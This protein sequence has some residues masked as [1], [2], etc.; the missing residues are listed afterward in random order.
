MFN[1]KKN[2]LA[3]VLLMGMAASAGANAASNATVLWSGTVPTTT[4]SDEI[5]ITG[6][7]GDTTALNGTITPSSDGVFESDAIVL[8]SH[9]N[10]GDA[11][12]PVVGNALV[13]A[14]WNL[15]D[16][17]VT[18]DGVANPKQEVEV[19][20][21]GKPFVAGT[22]VEATTISTKVKQTV[23]L[24]EAEVG[25]TTVQASVTVMADVA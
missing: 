23:P 22:S 5:I 25:G 1:F 13:N 3:S 21:N 6:L 18:F 17:S 15:V 8:E 7:G 12:A 4:A 9:A 19:S 11:A 16:V 10:T 20:V 24:P 14:N 2:V